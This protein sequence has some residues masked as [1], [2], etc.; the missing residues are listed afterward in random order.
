MTSTETRGWSPSATRTD[1]C[2][3]ADRLEPD[4]HGA[5]E[6]ALRVRVDDAAFRPPGDRVLDRGRVPSEDHDDLPHPGCSES[7]ED[8]LEDRPAGQRRKQLAATEPRPGARREHD[9][10][11]PIAHTA[12][13]PPVPRS[14]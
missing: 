12:I 9:S 13:F 10:H 8:V 2:A 5:R 7:V 6:A 4:P 3:L 1:A 11:R 14:G